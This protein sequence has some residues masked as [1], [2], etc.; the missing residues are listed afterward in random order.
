MRKWWLLAALVV[1]V[2]VAAGPVSGLEGD[3]GIMFEVATT[4]F[5][6]EPATQTAIMV[7]AGNMTDGGREL[8]L[9]R[10]RVLGPGG[11]KLAQEKVLY[12]KLENV[13]HLAT[14]AE[15]K[16]R[17][18]LGGPVRSEFRFQRDEFELLR[19][20]LFG[21]AIDLD[22]RSL[23]VMPVAGT[24]IDFTVRA[25]FLGGGKPI[26]I[27]RLC[28]IE[29]RNALPRPSA[30]SGLSG[31][32][33]STAATS[34]IWYWCA[35]DAHCHTAF[36]DAFFISVD[37]RV[38]A[39]DDYGFY[40]LLLTDHAQSMTAAD[41]TKELGEAAAASAKYGRTASAGLEMS[42]RKGDN[43]NNNDSHYLAYNLTSFVS[44]PKPE[45]RDGQ[46]IISAVNA[47]N[48]PNSFGTIAHPYNGSYPWTYWSA[49]GYTGM[50]LVSGLEGNANAQTLAKWDALLT[51]DVP[52]ALSNGRFT[53][54]FGN[55]DA[56]NF[57]YGEHM[58]FLLLPGLTPLPTDVY[59]AMRY[60]RAV[61]STDGSFADFTVNG[62]GI[63]TQTAIS[64]GS[65]ININVRAFSV[66]SSTYVR[67]FRVIGRNGQVLKTLSLTGKLASYQ[68]TISLYPG[69]AGYP[70][71]DGYFRVEATF[72]YDGFWSDKTWYVYCNPVFFDLI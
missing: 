22:L 14:P 19:P 50:E 47:N 35:G 71:G 55:S 31:E 18:G 36:S 57:M 41:Y 45:T 8:H 27:E 23:G 59:D 46:G 49:T 51:A 40:W 30:P 4:G 38:G 67:S 5:V 15:V 25:E 28:R 48:P 63:G 21:G 44:N 61:V 56:H 42:S 70:T 64:S 53:V 37:S 26:T 16:A 33:R 2:A 17:L 24:S 9:A 60:G 11:K 65:I 7:Y 6:R 66:D 54:G 13:A 68:G 29:V 1:T 72:L 20:G 12:H 39:M 69:E 34:G 58:T 62:A 10:I 3:N 52:G 43:G 32:M